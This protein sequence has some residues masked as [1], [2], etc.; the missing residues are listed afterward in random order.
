M[1]NNLLLLAA[2]AF[3]L[4]SCGS[5]QIAEESHEEHN[6]S[7]FEL[8]NLD[9]NAH[10]CED[11]YQFAIGGWLKE[12]PVP[13]TESRWAVFNVLHKEN[14]T[15]LQAILDEIVNKEHKKGT[16]AQLIADLYKAANDSLAR[17][18]E[19]MTALEPYLAQA[20]AITSIKELETI[21]PLWS[22]LGANSPLGFYVGADGKNSSQNITHASQSGMSLPDKEYY[23]SE[24]EKYQTI[25]TKY[26]EH[27]AKVYDLLGLENGEVHAENALKME[28]EIAKISWDR[29]KMRDPNLRYNK[30]TLQSFEA[31]LENMEISKMLANF[32]INGI[33]TIIIGQPSYFTDLNDL[34]QNMPI[35]TIK[36]YLNWGLID[37]YAA[38]ISNDLEIQN[39]AFYSTTLKG[40]KEMKPKNERVLNY[41]NGSL[42][43]PLG[44]LFVEKHFP[45]ESKEYIAEMIEN[46]RKAYTNSIANLTWMSNETKEKAYE[47]LAAFTYK[48]GY[49]DKWKDYSKLDISPSKLLQNNIN[50]RKHGLQFMLDKVGQPVDR[51]EWHM[52]PQTINAYYNPSNNEIVFPAAILQPPFFSPDFDAAINYGGI[53]GV[54]GHEFTHGFDD[55]GSKFDKEGNINNWWTE[56]DR[57]AFGKLTSK[58]S[59]QYSSYEVIDGMS[60]KGDMTLGENIADLGGVTLSFEALKMHLGEN[61][62]APIDGFTWQQRFFL[63]WAN[64]W[65]NSITDEELKNRLVTDYHSPGKYRVMGPLSNV[66]AF[67]EAFGGS[68]QNKTMIKPDSTKIKIW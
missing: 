41:V 23:L 24:E 35:E 37:A 39:F 3:L 56:E 20:N 4:S 57:A 47:K 18:K 13:S 25:R 53:G 15:K 44:K 5:K 12:N 26:K 61:T 19:G 65:K 38:A 51:D 50:L 2:G 17:E 16:D 34:L 68:C 7:A 55:Q 9:S 67:E 64:V 8:S 6:H 28:T 52:T 11:F 30:M 33:D 1:N 46:L 21:L 42:G 58:L 45:E 29:T 32:G 48:I 14:E 54:I 59:E 31:S 43:Q 49:P 10:A 60:I 66:P 36:S 40:V 22:T 63:G 62:P 27:I